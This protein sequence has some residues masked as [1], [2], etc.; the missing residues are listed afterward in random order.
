[1]TKVLVA[2]VILVAL[3]MMGA[4]YLFYDPL[5]RYQYGDRKAWHERYD[6]RKGAE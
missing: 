2:L 1:M 4:A 3:V 5:D 6:P